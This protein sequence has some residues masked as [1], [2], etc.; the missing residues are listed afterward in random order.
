MTPVLNDPELQALFEK[1]G[2]IILPG[3]L[4]PEHL[5]RLGNL[6]SEFN[7]QYTEPF[8]SSHFSKDKAYKQ[9][10]HETVSRTVFARAEP[11]L[12]A[13]R[14]IFG[15]LMVKQPDP[16]NFLQMHAD[17]TYVDETR[18]RSVSVWIPLVDTDARNGCLGVIEGS[19][20]I[21]NLIRGPGIQQNHFVHDREWVKKYGKLLPMRAGDAIV[22]DHALLHFSPAN[23]SGAIRPALNLSL[24]PRGVPVI[25]YCIPEGGDVSVIEKYEVTDDSFY[26][27]YDNFQRPELGTPVET[28]PKS[29]V[30]FI[31]EKM[32]NY[33]RPP[34]LFKRM[35]AAFQKNSRR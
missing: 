16:A 10:V 4:L 35:L 20:Q 29:V 9:H 13:F 18:H 6:F 15:N 5:E 23:V 27:R 8:H 17:W 24:V 19:H 34:G 2:Y 12:N 25:H 3:L 21:M 26:I 30:V 7:G 14:P 31:D 33:G 11:F 32:E 22:Y 28:L 1:N